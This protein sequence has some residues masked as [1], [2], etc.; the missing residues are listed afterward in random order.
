[1]IHSMTGYGKSENSDDNHKITVEIRSLNSKAH[2]IRCKLP[3][4]Y[5]EKELAIRNLI[6]SELER[7]KIE[8]SLINE[9]SNG[10]NLTINTHL[11]KEYYHKLNQL[12]DE[13]GEKNKDLFPSIVR[14]PNVFRESDFKVSNEEWA[15]A[16]IS[17]KS[18]VQKIKSYRE[19]E[20]R[21]IE[22]DLIISL[23]GITDRFNEI[24]A[25]DNDRKQ[26]LRNRM[27]KLIEEMSQNN[28]VDKDRFE[29]EVLFYLEKLDINEE[30][31][32][33]MQHCS[34]F[35]EVLEDKS[36]KSKGRKLSFIG[37]EMG[38]EINTLGAKAQYSPLQKIVVEMKEN[39]EKIKE[40]LANVL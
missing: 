3:V 39:L 1:M 19:E 36:T 12:A 18:A 5:N 6:I 24:E 38:R 7:G 34:Y 9:V 4:G 10:A 26:Y 37:Q 8:L 2:E 27:N 15:V 25:L 13:L 22:N 31:I 20:G 32:R 30:K 33:L 40:Q 29:Q 35:V 17:L 28:K 14:I 16:E 21:S 11:F 23:H